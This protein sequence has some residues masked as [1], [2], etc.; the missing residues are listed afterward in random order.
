MSMR[1]AVSW[2]VTLAGGVAVGAIFYAAMP[3]DVRAD[4]GAIVSDPWNQPAV[5]G[6][7]T[8]G[9]NAQKKKDAAAAGAKGEPGERGP[10]GVR[11]LD[12][13]AIRSA[14]AG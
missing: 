2:L 11:I 5:T 7:V 1:P 10:Q 8:V 12:V 14:N 3:G 6:S 9:Q 4:I 13:P